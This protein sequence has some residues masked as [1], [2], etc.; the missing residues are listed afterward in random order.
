MIFHYRYIYGENVLIKTI[1]L[2]YM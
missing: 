2:Y 1:Y